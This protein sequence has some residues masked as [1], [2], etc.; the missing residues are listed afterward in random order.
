MSVQF[1]LGRSGTGKTSLCIK[2]IVNALL[3]SDTAQRLILLVPEQAT[4]QAERAILAD[5]ALAGY[6][7]STTLRTGCSGNIAQPAPQLN[8]LSFDRLQFL[9]LGKKTATPRLSQIG[10]QMIIHRILR[11]NKNS[12]K[13]FGSSATCPGLARQMAET[14]T[15]LHQYAKTQDDI[16]Q[17]LNELRKDQH[18]SLTALKFADIALILKQYLQFIEGA[19]LDPDVQLNNARQAVASA[20]FLK[21]AKLW[22]D[23]FAGFT[24]AE[25]AIL[26]ELLKT[27]ADA[28][29]AL[30]LNPSNIDFKNDNT[31]NIDTTSLFYP[32]EYTYGQLAELV[33]KCKLPLAEPVILDEPVRFSDSRTLAH[34]ERQ[35]FEPTPT[36]IT[37]ADNIR[38]VSAANQRAEVRFV[39]RQ[40]VRLV[41]ENNYRYRDIAVIASDIDRYQHYIMAY[42]HD[43]GIPF[44]I[45][46]RKP[47]NQHPAVGLICSALQ[48]VTSGFS[49]SDIF[50]YLKTD[51]VPI[52]RCE[53]DLLENYCLAF[54]ITGSDWTDN[55]DWHFAGDDEQFDE[56]QINRIRQKVSRPLLKLRDRLCPPDNPE[57][58]LSAEQFTQI[59]FDFINC[60]KVREKIS[61]WIEQAQQ[62]GDYTAVDE[63]RQFYDKLLNV[64]DELVEVFA[65]GQMNCEDYFAIINS[66]FSQLTLAFIPPGLDEVLVGSIERSRHPDLKAVFL[67]GTTQKQFPSPITYSG[68]LTDDDRGA[69][70]ASD[71]ALAAATDRTLAER[72]YL[73][74]I[75]FTRPSQFLFLTYP[76][77]DEKG[78]AI[79]RSQFIE[80]IESLF[81]NLAEESITDE[82]INLDNIYTDTELADLL[83]SRLGK[84]TGEDE[85][86]DIGRLL[87][88]ICV[89]SEL[90]GLG[91]GVR[92]AID[93]DNTASLDKKIVAQLSAGQTES[94]ATRLAAFAACPYQHFA[95]YILKLEERKEF[96]LRP[97][98]VGGFYH[99]VL[100]ALL[101]QINAQGKD[102]ASLQNDQML[103]ILREQI[104]QI[105]SQDSFISN[106]ARHSAHNNFIIHSAGEVLEDCVLA[107]AQ[108]VR[109]GSFR[110]FLSE[111]SFGRTADCG[112]KFGQYRI[113]LPNGRELSLNGKID[114]LDIAKSDGKEITIVFDYKKS[115]DKAYFN[116]A[117]FYYGLDMQL[118][119][120]MLAVPNAKGAFYI[121][122]EI[123]LPKVSLDELPK[124]TDSFNHTARGIFNGRIF[125][126]LDGQV[127]TG[128]NKFYNFYISKSGDQYGDYGKSGALRPN[129]FQG[130]LRFTKKKIVELGEQILSGKIDVRPYRLGGKS[131][132]G[133]CRY[134]AV[135][136]FDWQINEY[137]FLET[138]G[139]TKVLEQIGH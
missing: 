107:I 53:V 109:A 18:N 28:Q 139:K 29:V 99:R 108:M 59:I 138:L 82:K 38:I 32:T 24:T 27:V 92:S 101:K 89:D 22:V 135:C 42:F 41:R 112:D 71:F 45:D 25:L 76:A 61:E 74:Y 66:A 40:I 16:D 97:L 23:G 78:S 130:V 17:L 115:K 126:Q 116:W 128:W 43:Y 123:N 1:I 136:R 63:H 117:R 75:A 36:R 131:P 70:E 137:N 81:E 95:R 127:C 133:Y 8:V 7:S 102:F 118:P 44:F 13:A 105:K 73:A 39:A 14:V 91:A 134:K 121:P 4:Y 68:I 49:G 20:D 106:F 72:Q 6:T 57:K 34:I 5:P 9:L 79:A 2:A 114:R 119:I 10:R 94:S 26:R 50:A 46:R 55:K 33:K 77:I 103:E 96:K 86:D 21:G 129:D 65:S 100:D 80:S 120:Y 30:C 62:A 54:G 124:K 47:L 93:Y 83:C 48:T 98:D 104:V 15:E 11:D 125:R 19:L 132:C 60:L 52:E 56:G 85:M 122:I 113:S 58:T 3:A 37:A 69:A 111:V 87:D 64:F 84:D 51:L 88:D 67:I 35:I 90:T 31:K 12:L 110:P